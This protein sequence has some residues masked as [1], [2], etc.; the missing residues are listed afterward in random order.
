MVCCEDFEKVGA[1]T[2]PLGPKKFFSSFFCILCVIFT[3][4]DMFVHIMVFFCGLFIY[5]GSVYIMWDEHGS[6][7][8]FCTFCVLQ[9]WAFL[10][11]L[12][13]FAHSLGFI[14][15]LGVLRA[16]VSYKVTR[17][18]PLI[19]GR[20][21]KGFWRV[22]GR[23]RVFWG[24]YEGPGG[25]T[26]PVIGTFCPSGCLVLHQIRFQTPYNGPTGQAFQSRHQ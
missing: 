22:W 19:V 25:S 12:A 13:V 23:H 20:V 1:E 14:G 7:F 8:S 6:H 16:I 11:D 9:F 21:T 5:F 2:R 18:I 3:Q 10:G 17:W 15:N 24:A 4:P 26:L